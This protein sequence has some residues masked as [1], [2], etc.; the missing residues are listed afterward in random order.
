MNV[1]GIAGYKNSG[2]TTLIVELIAELTAR[3]LRVATIKHAHHEFDIDH[4]GK[5][6]YRHREAG[7]TEVMVASRRRWAQVRELQG[8]VEPTLDELLNRLGPADIVLVEGYKYGDHPKLEIRRSALDH[9]P[10]AEESGNVCAVVSDAP[11]EGLSVPLLARDD[12]AAIADFILR[13]P[14]SE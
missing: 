4:P 1:F 7:A 10:L 12:V 14:G 6:S 11:I 2:K 13:E 5:D 8:T 9:P 3:G